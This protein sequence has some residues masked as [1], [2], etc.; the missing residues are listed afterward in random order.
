MIKQTLVRGWFLLATAASLWLASHPV[1]VAAQALATCNIAN[2]ASGVSPTTAVVFTFDENMNTTSGSADFYTYGGAPAP[3][4]SFTAVWNNARQL[5]CTP[6][7]AW[8]ANTM[9]LWMLTCVDLASEMEP[10]NSGGLFTTGSGG[11]TVVPET[12][13][14]TNRFTTYSLGRA[15]HYVQTGPATPT[16]DTDIGYTFFG[17]CILASNRPATN[18]V[19]TLASSQAV[20]MMRNNLQLENFS[21]AFYTNNLSLYDLIVPAG[22]YTFSVRSNGGTLTAP[23]NFPASFLQ[24]GIPQVANYAA[25]QAINASQ[26]FTL[27]WSAFTGG[28]AAEFIQL[29]IDNLWHTPDAGQLGALSGTSTQ[30]VIPAN[31]LARGSNYQATLWF[32]RMQVTSNGVDSVTNISRSSITRFN[33][34]TAGGSSTNA[35]VLSRPGWVPGRGFAFDLTGTAGQ[36]ITVEQRLLLTQGTWSVLF[37]TNHP[38]GTLRFTNTPTGNFQFL[39]A[40]VN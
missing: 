15:Y 26:P 19:L 28:T 22:V 20:P 29:E 21:F 2:M 25:A 40:R 17:G 5:T 34:T 14:G 10:I 35:P 23:V 3:F 13:T 39:R 36:V 32:T 31:T 8:P 4:T 37:S 24:P 27:S 38:G 7:T 30:A 6:T 12:G 11:G 33:L 1:N 18:V 16:L 9:M